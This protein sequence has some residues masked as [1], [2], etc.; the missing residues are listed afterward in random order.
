MKGAEE[1]KHN[2]EQNDDEQHLAT[3]LQENCLESLA[4]RHIH[5]EKKTS[6]L[7]PS[8]NTTTTT[9]TTTTTATI[10]TTSNFLR[11]TLPLGLPWRGGRA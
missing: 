5:M 9:T 4:E 10:I 11:A 1:V 6:R 7:F 2:Q 8:W 3:I